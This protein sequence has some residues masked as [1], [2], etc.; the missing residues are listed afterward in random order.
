[1]SQRGPE[2]IS[3]SNSDYSLPGL[4]SASSSK[5]EIIKEYKSGAKYQGQ[6]EG[7]RKAGRGVFVWPNG[8]KYEGEF[9]DNY[10]Q[11]KGTTT[12]GQLARY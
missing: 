11:G 1:M 6:V 3:R 7:T 2:E 8:A 4:G 10:R 12:V 9:V 5:V